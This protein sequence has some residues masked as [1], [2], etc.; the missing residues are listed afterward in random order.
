MRD[1]IRAS[2]CRGVWFEAASKSRGVAAPLL[3]RVGALQRLIATR[4]GLRGLSKW[5]EAFLAGPPRVFDASSLLSTRAN[6]GGVMAEPYLIT[7]GDL[8]DTRWGLSSIC[9]I[10]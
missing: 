5:S 10:V 9:P 4:A 3:W 7:R 6:G 1:M 8:A 2:M